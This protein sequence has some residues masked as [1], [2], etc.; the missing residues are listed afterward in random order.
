MIF[1]GSKVFTH[2]RYWQIKK[3][4]CIIFLWGAPPPP[5]SYA[6]ACLFCFVLDNILFCFVL[7]FIGVCFAELAARVPKAG[8]AYVYTYVTM[9]E[10]IGFF[11]GW[12]VL[13]ENVLG[14]PMS[15]ESYTNF[16]ICN[17]KMIIKKYILPKSYLRVKPPR[18][19]PVRQFSRNRV[20]GVRGNLP[21][22]AT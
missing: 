9:G 20:T 12:S 3:Y 11:V 13:I 10:C 18:K 2:A 5:H 22:S 14:E 4:V 6:P 17:L 16:A 7:F 8:S 15:L 1:V 19:S 21:V